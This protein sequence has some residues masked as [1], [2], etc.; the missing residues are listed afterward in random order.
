MQVSRLYKMKLDAMVESHTTDWG[1][2]ACVSWCALCSELYATAAEGVLTCRSARVT[3]SQTGTR[4]PGS[5]PTHKQIS[6]SRATYRRW[7]RRLLYP[8]HA[9]GEEYRFVRHAQS[10]RLRFKWFN[11]GPRDSPNEPHALP[12][13]GLPSALPYRTLHCNVVPSSHANGARGSRAPLSCSHTAR[14][15]AGLLSARSDLAPS[16]QA[17]LCGSL[18]APLTPTRHTHD[19]GA[20]VAAHAPSRRWQLA[21]YI[22]ALRGARHTWREVYWHLWGVMHVAAC[23]EC[24]QFFPLSHLAQCWYGLTALHPNPR[25]P[26]YRP[27]H[28]RIHVAYHFIRRVRFM[29]LGVTR[30]TRKE[31]WRALEPCAVLG[32]RDSPV[33]AGAH[34]Q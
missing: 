8:I 12:P 28:I 16:L 9:D 29:C 10:G 22:Q 4:D 34:C 27:L 21:R 6:E 23:A 13:G 14:T 24:L 2:R 17:Y 31:K 5:L 32:A 3:V 33:G 11:T 18:A 30:A 7:Q 20:V 25:N 19:A 26:S 15:R 1:S